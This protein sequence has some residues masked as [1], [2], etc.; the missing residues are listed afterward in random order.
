MAARRAEQPEAVKAAAE[1]GTGAAQPAQDDAPRAKSAEGQVI[2]VYPEQELA[3]H[4]ATKSVP[5]RKCDVDS[6]AK[7]IA[8]Y[9]QL[10]PILIL[11]GKIIAGRC[12]YLA[13]R[14]LGIPCK[15]IELKEL[16]GKT[17]T[18]WVLV[19]L[20]ESG[21]MRRLTDS[22]LALVAARN[23]PEHYGPET[24]KR[25]L[26]GEA[27]PDGDAAGTACQDAAKDFGL[28]ANRVKQA[29]A[30]VKSEIT[31]L[32]EAVVDG[33][34]ITTAAKIAGYLD[35][36]QDEKH[37]QDLLGAAKN[38]NKERIKELMD[39]G[40][41]AIDLHGQKIPTKLKDH[42][43]AARACSK[44]ERMLTQVSEWVHNLHALGIADSVKGTD[45]R[46]TADELSRSMPMCM[47]FACGAQEPDCTACDGR[48]WLHK[49]H[50]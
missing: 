34:P 47:C 13:C 26:N 49:R 15:A 50:R 7:S 6:L 29:W 20:R 2:L 28:K 12:R 19:E 32:E 5:I 38:V 10:V 42:F 44:Y 27:P 9:G 21:K 36:L 39:G 46:D 4:D 35:G 45:L 18:E 23:I 14:Q 40:N 30:V 37:R 33:L 22:Q 41:R 11:Q 31:E 25:M 8:Q 43:E 16:G 48:G 24:E 1:S 3:F 17:P